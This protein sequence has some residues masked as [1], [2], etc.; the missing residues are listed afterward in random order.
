MILFLDDWKKYPTAILHLSTKN[1]SFIRMAKVLK[2][3]GIKNNAFMLALLNPELEHIDPHSEDLTIE[4]QLA[5]AEECENNPWY[6]FREVARAPDDNCPRMVEANRGNIALWWCFFLHIT[7][8]LIQPRQTGKSFGSSLLDTYLMCIGA[9]GTDINM[10]TKDA[11]LKINDVKRLKECIGCLPYYL[12]PRTKMDSDNKEDVTISAYNNRYIVHVSQSSEKGALKLGRGM[13][14][15]IVKI[16]EAP[17]IDHAEL[18]IGTILAATGAAFDAARASGAHYGIVFTTTA[19]KLNTDSGKYIYGLLQTSMYWN[20]IVYD[21]SNESEVRALVEK[22]GGGYYRVNCTFNHRQLGKTD[23]WLV[24][25]IK[26]STQ[27]G[28]EADRDYFNRWTIG[29]ATNPLSAS[30][31]EAISRSLIEPNFVHIAKQSSY[32]MRWYLPKE[33]VFQFMQS[34]ATIAGLDLSNAAGGDNIALTIIRTTNG[35][36]IARMDVN[37]TNIMTFSK[38]L[39]DLLIAFPRLTL[40]PEKASQS[41]SVVDYLAIILPSYGIDPLKRIFNTVVHNAIRDDEAWN[42]IN[43]PVERRL[44]GWYERIKKTF[45]FATAGSG[46]FSRSELYST[47]LMNAVNYGGEYMKDQVLI[48]EISSLIKK[49]NRVDHAVGKNDDSVISWL[50]PYWLLTQ[51]K[52]LHIYGITDILTEIK[53]RSNTVDEF[54]PDFLNQRR[55][56]Q[57]F[58]EIKLKLESENDDFIIMKLENK[59]RAISTMIHSGESEVISVTDIID[60]IKEKRKMASLSSQSQSNL[61]NYGSNS[62]WTNPINQ[63]RL[64]RGD[65]NQRFGI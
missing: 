5:V 41:T 12:N 26:T 39:A 33:S 58:D 35:E 49:D 48:S 43:I 56:R 24:E 30:Q 42:L 59:L 20:E 34:E 32:A 3:M 23:E 7:I 13:T 22:N 1:R 57:E 36:V 54:D 61:F 53:N 51:G 31:L 29:T 10:L 18:S 14:S 60:S 17:Y 16:D 45:G 27:T 8:F 63:Y 25:K 46:M 6:F 52:N 21:C 28:E 38:W 40:M 44:P 4:Q 9:R 64:N 62:N 37:E 50:L 2:S 15:R 55:L 11:T 47:T 65:Q 19:G